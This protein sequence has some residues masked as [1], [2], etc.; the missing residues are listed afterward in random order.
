MSK[1][2][3]EI[4]AAAQNIKYCTVSLCSTH[5]CCL[6][7]CCC[8]HFHGLLPEVGA[9]KLPIVLPQSILGQSCPISQV[10]FQSH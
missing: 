5:C 3:E 4:N 2:M 7:S 10:R 1:E 8:S 9:S 6:V